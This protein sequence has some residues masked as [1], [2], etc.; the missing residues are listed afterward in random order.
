MNARISFLGGEK[1]TTEHT[2]IARKG[3]PLL[4]APIRLAADGAQ[5]GRLETDSRV[6]DA[7]IHF[8]WM[9]PAAGG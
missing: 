3:T 1:A 9:E 4:S 8:M 2:E 5:D 6:P 7:P